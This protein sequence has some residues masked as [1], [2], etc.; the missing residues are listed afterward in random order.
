MLFTLLNGSP[1]S[2]KIAA[3]IPSFLII[4]TF[5]FPV[6]CLC[7]PFVIAF[8]DAQKGRLWILLV[9]GTLIGPVSMALWSLFLQLRGEDPHEIWYGDPLAG[10]GGFACIIFALIV[11]FLT[12]SIYLV[13]LR[14]LRRSSTLFLHT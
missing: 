11:G 14:A 1:F 9:G 13:S 10:I 8:K 7:L 5:A 4:M 3:I 6:W 2:Y 12:T